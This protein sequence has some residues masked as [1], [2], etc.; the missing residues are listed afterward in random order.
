MSQS[1]PGDRPP[2]LLPVRH[3]LLDALFGMPGLPASGT[4]AAEQGQDYAMASQ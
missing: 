3:L 2:P 1:L 4:D